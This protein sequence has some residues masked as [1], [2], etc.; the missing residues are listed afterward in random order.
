VFDLVSVVQGKTG[1]DKRLATAPTPILPPNKVFPDNKS[2]VK[3]KVKV[4]RKKKWRLLRGSGVLFIYS[5]CRLSV[6]HS[7]NAFVFFSLYGVILTFLSP[8]VHPIFGFCL[9]KCWYYLVYGRGKAGIITVHPFFL[10]RALR[11][12]LALSL[13]CNGMNCA[14]L[15]LQLFLIHSSRIKKD[16]GAESLEEK[17]SFWRRIWEANFASRT[18]C[19]SCVVSMTRPPIL[20][21]T[22]SGTGW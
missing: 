1:T 13:A 12:S 7:S 14:L 8:F 11:F 22:H 9:A 18:C 17:E 10:P 20:N 19:L 4:K 6:A 21:H 2:T 16:K 15:V 5:A 3:S